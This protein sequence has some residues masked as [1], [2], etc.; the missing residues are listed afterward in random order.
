MQALTGQDDLVEDLPLLQIGGGED[1]IT[2]SFR[3]WEGD[4]VH[5][6][7][8]LPFGDH[9]T[10]AFH[11]E[12]GHYIR[13][14]LRILVGQALHNNLRDCRQRRTFSILYTE[15]LNIMIVRGG[16]KVQEYT[17]ANWLLAT[18]SSQDL[19]KVSKGTC[20]TRAYKGSMQ[21]EQACITSM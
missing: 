14:P 1:P 2:Y 15:G 17:A 12:S 20:N 10:D 19:R 11:G 3:V 18:N 5:L 13:Q 6:K 7:L 4:L 21:G 9:V 8:A 16:S